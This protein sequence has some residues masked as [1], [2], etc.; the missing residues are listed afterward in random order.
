MAGHKKS[1]F[2]EVESLLQDIGTKIEQLIEKAADAG[3]DAKVELE[4]K[5]RDLRERKTTVEEEFKKGKSKVETLYNSKKTEIE[6][7]L[8]KSQKHFKN[9]FKQLGEA[10]KVLIK[11]T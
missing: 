11:K 2:E 4:K 6:P 7:N 5:I 3:G 1:G 9:A 10:F 8:K